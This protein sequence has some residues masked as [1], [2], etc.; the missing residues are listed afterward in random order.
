MRGL[1][2]NERERAHTDT[3]MLSARG[4]PLYVFCTYLKCILCAR[5]II[6]NKK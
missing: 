1:E 6:P 3:S 5:R 4:G 2:R